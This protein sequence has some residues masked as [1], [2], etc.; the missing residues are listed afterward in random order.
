MGYREE[1]TQ[2]ALRVS[3]NPLPEKKGWLD[4]H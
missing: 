2:N 4:Y 1:G 3:K